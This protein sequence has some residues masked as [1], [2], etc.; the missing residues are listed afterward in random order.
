VY[1]LHPPE[2]INVST[3]SCESRNSTNVYYSGI[4]PKKIVSKVSYMLQRNGPVNDK[5]WGIMQQSVYGTKI[6]DIYDVQKMLDAN[7]G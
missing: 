3:L 5:I 4:L 6:Y 1:E 2:L 7:L